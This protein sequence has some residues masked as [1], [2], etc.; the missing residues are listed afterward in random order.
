MLDF[1]R[2]MLPTSAMAQI[3]CLISAGPTREYLDPVRFLSNPS[4][5]KMGYSLAEAAAA[6]G[7]HVEL[8][9]GPVCMAPPRDV[10]VC[11]VVS[12]DEML[13]AIDCRF[14]TCDILIMAAAVGDWRPKVREP[15][16]L[17]KGGASLTI[18]LEPTVDIL[19][20][21]AA[22]KKAGQ[23]VVG[24]AAETH[25]VEEYAREKLKAKNCDYI[26]ANRVGE[27]GSGFEA[28]EN[29]VTLIARTGK[30][31]E[32]GPMGKREIATRLVARF[33]KT[34]G[35]GDR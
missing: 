13:R 7:W 5:G 1:A 25:D 23:I 9:S 16:K 6:V 29:T 26:V 32:L 19:K 35:A 14:D 8:V 20:T 18:Q 27:P 11:R 24:F 17:K 4:S 12:A 30:P 34:L 31:E 21:I 15:R 28:D 3:R 33:A 10:S 22:R 2:V